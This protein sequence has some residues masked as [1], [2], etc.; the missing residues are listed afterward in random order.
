MGMRIVSVPIRNRGQSYPSVSVL[1]KIPN[2]NCKE[3]L[4]SIAIARSDNRLF[5][6]N[7]IASLQL[8]D[9]LCRIGVRTSCMVHRSHRRRVA[10]ILVMRCAHFQ[11]S[12]FHIRGCN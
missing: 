9:R 6:R 10:Y 1:V 12:Q 5:Y 7:Q 8:C 3:F 4:R 11:S 2:A